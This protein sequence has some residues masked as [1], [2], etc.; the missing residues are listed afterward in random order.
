MSEQIVNRTSAPVLQSGSMSTNEAVTRQGKLHGE[1]VQVKQ[2][3]SSLLEDA[4]EEVSLLFKERAEK[5]LARREMSTGKKENTQQILI[6][7][8][9]EMMDQVPDLL[10]NVKMKVLIERMA[11]NFPSTPQQLMRRLEEFSKDP[12]LQFV[13]LQVL[14]KEAKAGGADKAEQLKLI[15]NAATELMNTKGESVRAG[16]NV[17]LT[18]SEFA[19]RLKTDVQMLRDAYRDAVLNYGGIT[20]TYRTIVERHKGRPFETVRKFLMKALG[21]DYNAQGPSIEPSRLKAI[22]DDMYAL[23]LL[24]GVHEQCCD[25]MGTMRDIYEQ[26]D[27]K[28]GQDLMGKVL[29]IKDMDW[30]QPSQIASIPMEM[31][32]QGIENQIYLL[33]EVDTVF[34]EIPEKT[35]NDPA[36]RER[37]LGVSREALEQLFI[38][39]QEE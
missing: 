11:S 30:V 25:I 20:Q 19:D 36:D 22:M 16:L 28:D 37:L 27:C 12:T 13:A 6:E 29:D 26:R 7:K 32:V 15:Q 4:K 24:G 9:R 2:S 31:N 34:R 35:Y 17:S 33:R 3:A 14:E 38:K 5:T 18:A 1:N 21:A 23:K 10:K 39:E 8:I